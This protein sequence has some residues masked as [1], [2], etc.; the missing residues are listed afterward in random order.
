M[1]EM[2]SNVCIC[3]RKLANPDQLLN[4]HENRVFTPCGCEGSDGQGVMKDVRRYY[5]ILMYVY[6]RIYTKRLTRCGC[7][8]SDGQGFVEEVRRYTMY[9]ECV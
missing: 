7:G 1:S 3:G 4:V 9:T 5:K 8:S 6:G 2:Y